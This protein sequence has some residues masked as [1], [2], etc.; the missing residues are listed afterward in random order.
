MQMATE[1]SK[2]QLGYLKG[3][4]YEGPKP[5]T[6]WEAGQLIDQ[7]KSGVSSARASQWLVARRD[8][9]AKR[10]IEEAKQYLDGV[11]RMDRDYRS[12]V[13][14]PLTSGFRLKV[15][16]GEQTAENEIYHKAFLSLDVATRYPD[17]LAIE[18]MDEEEL[19]R[20]P[21]HGK[22]VTGPGQVIERAKGE[23]ASQKNSG[24]AVFIVAAGGM[25]LLTLSSIV[26]L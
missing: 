18:G 25:V 9:K 6:S 2:K 26:A 24:C 1:P 4:G 21:S 14:E 3:L 16:A 10:R 23:T 17:L 8:D 5:A 20:V 13:G 12:A 22:F 15:M 19:K 7:L 11:V